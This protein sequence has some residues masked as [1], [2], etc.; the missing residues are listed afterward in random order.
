MSW[1]KNFHSKR[2]Q[3]GPFETDLLAVLC[4]RKDAT[5]RELLESG[6]INAAYTTVMTTLDR[7]FKKKFLERT[8]DGQSRAFRYRLKQNE[9]DFYRAVLGADLTRVLQASIDPTLPVS[10]LVDAVTEHDATL[11]E[12]LRRAVNRK[13]QQLRQKGKA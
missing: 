4:Q 11:L 13:R 10:Y 12:E 7:L 6:E 2:R 9:R 8:P 3:L 1:I 5:V